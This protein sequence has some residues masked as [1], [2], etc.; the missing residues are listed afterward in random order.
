MPDAHSKFSASASERWLACPGSMV[1]SV[2]A[3]R[4]STAYSAWGTLAHELA[5]KHLEEGDEPAGY[6]GRIFQVDGHAVTVDEDMVACI[7]SYAETVRDFKGDDGV[8]LVEQRVSY[9]GYL[10]LTDHQAFGTAD[11]IIARGEELIVVDLK[12]GVGVEVSAQQNTQMCLYALGALQAYQGVCADFKRVR[13]VIS[14]PRIKKA[15]SEWDCSVEYLEAWGRSDARMAVIYCQDAAT[16]YGTHSDWEARFLRPGEKQCRWCAA[17][18]TCPALRNE[19]LATA[20]GSAPASVDEFEAVMDTR[21]VHAESLRDSDADWIAA[22]LNKVDLIE[23]W[24]KAIRTEAER[25][26]FAGEEVPGYKV[27]AG[28]KGARAWDKSVDVEALLKTMRLKDDEMYDRKVISPTTAEKLAK[29][30]TIGP[31]QWGKL[32]EVITQSEGKPHVAPLS[33]SRPALEIKPVADDFE[34][35]A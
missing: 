10:D 13:M 9:G 34:K 16:T 24:C 7:T 23:D 18:A 3:E 5:A 12:T 28:K 8:L 1:L 19:V 4:T 27:V 31:R 33:D 20:V 14:Q 2:A 30:G 15:P 25:R 11:A 21:A 32:Q 26:L 29:A 6:L 22:C 35:L 17:K